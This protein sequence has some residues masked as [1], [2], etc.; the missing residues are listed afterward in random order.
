MFISKNSLI[1]NNFYNFESSES[2]ESDEKFPIYISDSYCNDETIFE[3]ANERSEIF[4]EE[5]ERNLN[6][7]L[8]MYRVLPSSSI[9]RKLFVEEYPEKEIQNTIKK[10][11]SDH[12]FEAPFDKQI[13]EITFK[14]LNLDDENPLRKI[15]SEEAELLLNFDDTQICEKLLNFLIGDKSL[16]DCEICN[17]VEKWV[18]QSIKDGLE[19]NVVVLRTNS[20]LGCITICYFSE[21]GFIHKNIGKASHNQWLAYVSDG[22]N[23]KRV[24]A[25]SIIDFCKAIVPNFKVENFLISDNEMHHASFY[26]RD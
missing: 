16:N 25:P 19:K 23:V 17:I 4:E 15:T 1:P 18:K 13:S 5:N 22:G 3:N 11:K 12:I 7:V 8:S 10:I 21:F 24:T 9:R 2:G 20:N 14:T 26:K 6:E